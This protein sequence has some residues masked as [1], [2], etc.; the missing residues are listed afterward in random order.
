MH[1]GVAVRLSRL[2][3]ARQRQAQPPQHDDVGIGRQRVRIH[4]VTRNEHFVVC[5]ARRRR[6][7]EQ[8]V[9]RIIAA[10]QALPATDE[11]IE[12]ELRNH[13]PFAAQVLH[14]GVAGR[15]ATEIAGDARRAREKLERKARVFLQPGLRVHDVV[16]ARVTHKKLHDARNDEQPQGE[17]NEQL[18]NREAPL[19]LC[20]F[21]ETHGHLYNLYTRVFMT[22]S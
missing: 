3:E 8:V 15:I 13:G 11:L 16:G 5:T 22:S 19:S 10:T 12:I 9:R 7:V 21:V 20:L 2:G 14:R 4:T 18:D 6:Q 1:H 17:R